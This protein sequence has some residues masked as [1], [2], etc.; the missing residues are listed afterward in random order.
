M[1]TIQKVSFWEV[2]Q[3][4]VIH[5][6][7]YGVCVSSCLFRCQGIHPFLEKS[8]CYRKSDLI[9]RIYDISF[10]TVRHNY[11]MTFYRHGSNLWRCVVF[12]MHF[13]MV[14]SQYLDDRLNNVDLTG[15]LEKNGLRRVRQY[16][17]IYVHP[18]TRSNSRTDAT[19]WSV[20]VLFS[21]CKMYVIKKLAKKKNFKQNF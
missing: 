16:T 4:Y 17:L 15:P 8:R 10:L 7:S 13:W 12:F 6:S 2:S 14:F 11:F 20:R 9:F 1:K 21:L 3:S 18:A 5:I 19:P